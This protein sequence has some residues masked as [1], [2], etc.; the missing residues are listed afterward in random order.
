MKSTSQIGALECTLKV[1][2]SDSSN[3]NSFAVSG[4]LGASWREMEFM[5]ICRMAM[6]DD[7]M[8]LGKK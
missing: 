2:C 5:I 4:V 7:V 6:M 1:F 8:E 3:K